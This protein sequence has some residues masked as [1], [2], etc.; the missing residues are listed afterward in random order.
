MQHTDHRE[1]DV[2]VVIYKIAVH[3]RVHVVRH[4]M[5]VIDVERLRSLGVCRTHID[6]Q[7]IFREDTSVIKSF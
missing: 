1:V 4:V 2:S 7:H 3:L 6:H 5:L